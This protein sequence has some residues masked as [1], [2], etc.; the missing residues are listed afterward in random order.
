MN[1][2]NKND[3]ID[4]N[5]KVSLRLSEDGYERPRK[6]FTDSIQT[7]EQ[8]KNKLKDYEEIEP[9]DLEIIKRGTK[10]RY[11][12]YDK[13]TGHEKLILGG[14]IL[15]V[16]PMYVLLKGKNEYTFCAQRYTLND[17][18]KVIH[19]TRFFR[20]INE[21][22]KLRERIELEKLKREELIEL[23]NERIIA[24]QQEIERLKNEL[25]QRREARKN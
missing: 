16:F 15:K 17:K 3:V 5:K 24:Q 7:K 23:C 21:E 22:S 14:N 2:K 12:K 13:E 19:I 6:T 1:S 10:V 18:G 9:E 25:K 4:K 11:I 8:I 20:Q